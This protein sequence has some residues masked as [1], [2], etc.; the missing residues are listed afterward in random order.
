[1][2]EYSNW[3]GL[4]KKNEARRK[5]LDSLVRGIDFRSKLRLYSPLSIKADRGYSRLSA[6]RS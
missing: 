2:N 5:F 1:M 6:K 4:S 3:L